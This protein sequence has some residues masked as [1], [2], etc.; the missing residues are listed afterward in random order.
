MVLGR[1]FDSRPRNTWLWAWIKY[2]LDGQH[3]HFPP[4]WYFTSNALRTTTRNPF[5]L[6]AVYLASSFADPTP[7]LRRTCVESSTNL[8]VPLSPDTRSENEAKV[9]VTYLI[10]HY[11]SR[12]SFNISYIVK[13]CSTFETAIRSRF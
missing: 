5:Y 4:V 12:L 10:R 7:I 6:F 1:E 8:P 11:L 9:F 13:A 2:S 3:Y